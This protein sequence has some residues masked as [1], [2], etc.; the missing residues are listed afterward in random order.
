MVKGIEFYRTIEG[1]CPVEEFLNLLPGKIAQKITW[2]LEILES[3]GVLPSNYFKKLKNSDI[4]ECRIQFGSNIYRLLGFFNDKSFFVLTNGFIQKTQK[5]P[6][7]EI[8]RAEKYKF[9]YITRRKI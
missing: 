2:L 7:N 3:K 5:T 1:K 8:E 9:D 4:W 6:I